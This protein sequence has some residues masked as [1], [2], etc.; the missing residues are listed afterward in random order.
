MIH[1][2]FKYIESHQPIAT[3]AT[4]VLAIIAV[5]LSQLWLDR[6]QRKDH[7]HEISLKEKEVRLNKKEELVECINE[8]IK[9]IT[10]VEGL[11]DSWCKDFQNSYSASEMSQLLRD[12]DNR[13]NKIHIIIQLYFE[14]Y[15]K[16]IDKIIGQAQG[17]HELCADH[18]MAARNSDFEFSQMDQMEIVE[19]CNEYAVAY[20]HLSSRLI[21]KT[22][23]KEYPLSLE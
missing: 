2:I 1:E 6:R 8:Q 16:Y 19:R 22:L 14:D 9:D 20:M 7:A 10:R 12:I 23:M 21:N 3:L 5:I 18:S 17:F 15:L 11:F 4:G 13:I